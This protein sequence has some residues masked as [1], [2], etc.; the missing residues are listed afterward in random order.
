MADWPSPLYYPRHARTC[1]GSARPSKDH[2]DL[3]DRL[4]MGKVR[5]IAQHFLA[6]MRECGLKFFCGVSP[7]I[8]QTDEWHGRA[9]G[10]DDALAH[11]GASPVVTPENRSPTPSVG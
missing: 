2:I 1:Q 9:I 4:N 3:D 10:R 5:Q 7:D 6:V 8:H 11:L